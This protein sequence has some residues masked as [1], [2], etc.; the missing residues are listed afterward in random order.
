MKNKILFSKLLLTAFLASFLLQTIHSIEHI[1]LEPVKEIC[2]HTN[3]TDSKNQITHTHDVVE[4]CN[5]CS[6]S[7]SSFIAKSVEFFNELN[8]V[9]NNVT[10][11]SFNRIINLYFK[12]SLFALRAPPV[13]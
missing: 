1:V 9:G 6:F 8:F 5:F 2:N 10:I 3:T 11:F 12:G 4:Q 7:I 13:L